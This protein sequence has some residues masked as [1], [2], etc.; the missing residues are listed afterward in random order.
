MAV[1]D[2]GC[3]DHDYDVRE[4]QPSCRVGH[5]SLLG[6]PSVSL[7]LESLY[8]DGEGGLKTQ[9][10]EVTLKHRGCTLK[11]RARWQHPWHN[12]QR[13]ALRRALMHIAEQ[14]LRRE[15]LNVT[16]DKVLPEC[17]SAGN[18]LMTK[19]GNTEYYALYGRQSRILPPWRH[20]YG[21][22]ESHRTDARRR[23]CK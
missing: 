7:L 19:G 17:I 12:D 2:N 4:T 22:K 20:Q 5:P 8:S 14:Q 21:V 13:S 18:A 6:L 9:N 23:G 10:V 11:V 3:A 16:T 15:G 1:A